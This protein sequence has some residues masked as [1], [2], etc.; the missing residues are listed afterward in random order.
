MST[1][2][3]AFVA[4]ATTAATALLSAK[5]ARGVEIDEP[6]DSGAI[7]ALSR[8]HGILERLLLV[9]DE[10]VQR[11][12]AKQAVPL[13]ALRDT[14]VLVRTYIEQFHE[15]VEE[16]FIFPR[17]EQKGR[18]V[19]LVEVLREQHD[20]GRKITERIIGAVDEHSVRDDLAGFARMMRAHDA[21]EDTVLFPALHHLLRPSELAKLGR[22]IEQR[23]RALFGDEGYV[24]TL[25]SVSDLELRF[26]IKDLAKLTMSASAPSTGGR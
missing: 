21:R 4:S 5:A 19:E 18:Y 12:D 15:R 1:T 25:A 6:F 24:R 11:V 17:F 13:S 23:E 10:A 14:A 16:E 9:Y 26:G 20:A 2:R 3:R 7:E 8:D 22:V